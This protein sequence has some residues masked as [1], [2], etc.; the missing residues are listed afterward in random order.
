MSRCV[1]V[2]WLRFKL[3]LEYKAH[4]SPPTEARIDLL[5]YVEVAVGAKRFCA[6]RLRRRRPPFFLR[7]PLHPSH[8]IQ[9]LAMQGTPHQTFSE[10]T[11][12]L[13]SSAGSTTDTAALHQNVWKRVE[14]LEN[15]IRAL[16]TCHNMA[17]FTCRLPVEILSRVF[18]FLAYSQPRVAISSPRGG[19]SYHWV[20]AVHIC[21]YWRSASVGCAELWAQ[22]DFEQPTEFVELML[23]RSK[24][25]PLDVVCRQH[26]I[27]VANVDILN[28]TLSQVRR[29]RSLTISDGGI[30]NNAICDRV[31]ALRPPHWA[32]DAPILQEVDILI[33]HHASTFNLPT[34]FLQGGAPNLT[35]FKYHG[36]DFRW[37]NLPCGLSNL[38]D[39]RLKVRLG[40]TPVTPDAFLDTFRQMPLLHTL[41]LRISLNI[42][43][44]MQGTLQLLNVS[45]LTFPAL[46]E[47]EMQ[48]DPRAINDFLRL[49]RS[50]TVASVALTSTDNDITTDTEV[51]QQSLC[52][53]LTFW[54]QHSQKPNVCQLYLLRDGG[55]AVD[56][57]ASVVNGTTASPEGEKQL[58]FSFTN[59]IGIRPQF[60]VLKDLFGF[61]TLVYLVVY[62]QGHGVLGTEEWRFFASL[63][64]LDVVYLQRP[65]A[66]ETADFVDVFQQDTPRGTPQPLP[67]PSLSVITLS[68]LHFSNELEPGISLEEFMAKFTAILTSRAL[69]FCPIKTLQIEGTEEIQ[70][71]EINRLQAADP[72]LTIVS[73]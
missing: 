9:P 70:E 50:S 73:L 32:G 36:H 57:G 16:K 21:R 37:N 1:C 48:D 24:G 8:S 12:K 23:E 31:G 69:S 30:A 49:T 46:R 53:V 40:S 26:R 5:M 43:S 14:D 35:R 25:A 17:T 58:S 41:Y 38:T 19:K 4:K 62:G 54:C 68:D 20:K 59:H 7:P 29:I 47:F 67:F 63:P 15:E 45:P 64:N 52:N 6:V 2:Q 60:N 72:G 44:N 22:L 55:V 11:Q 39:L 34:G 18:L 42:R 56:F 65:F 66:E 27:S 3:K 13:I 61:Q 51:I 28:K 10:A 33:I 71:D